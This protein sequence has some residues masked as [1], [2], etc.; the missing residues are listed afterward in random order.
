V[1]NPFVNLSAIV[2]LLVFAI[3]LIPAILFLGTAKEKSQ[4]E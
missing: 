4:R 3:G 1:D 2:G